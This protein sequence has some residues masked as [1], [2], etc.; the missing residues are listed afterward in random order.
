[1]I[2]QL[3]AIA[4]LLDTLCSFNVSVFYIHTGATLKNLTMNNLDTKIEHK[5]V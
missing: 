3:C 2:T 4:P 1:M 5:I